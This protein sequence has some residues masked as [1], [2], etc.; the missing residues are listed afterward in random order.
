MADEKQVVYDPD[1]YDL[2]TDA[3]R[4]LIAQYPGLDEGDSFSFSTAPTGAGKAIFP[5][6]GAV[7]QSEIESITGHVTQTCLY[8]FTVLFRASGLSQKNRVTA[9]EWLDTFGRWLEKQAVVINHRRY[10][11]VEYPVLRTAGKYDNLEEKYAHCRQEADENYAIQG[12]RKIL[13]ITRQTPAYLSSVGEDKSEDWVISMVLMYR[14]E[15]D[16]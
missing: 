7:I 16:R 3:L 1:G 9:K 15:F 12:V 5:T 6:T 11:L 2:V 4:A 8:P 14:N 13:N 10:I